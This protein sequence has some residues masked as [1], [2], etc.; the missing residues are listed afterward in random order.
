MKLICVRI[1]RDL[2]RKAFGK[3]FKIFRIGHILVLSA[4]GVFQGGLQPAG[5]MIGDEVCLGPGLGPLPPVVILSACHVAP[6]GTGAVSVADMLLREG[7]LAV[8]GLI[9]GL[10]LIFLLP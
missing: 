2:G 5:L 8:L 1:L 7:A 6:R 4:H 10:P 3:R 9:V